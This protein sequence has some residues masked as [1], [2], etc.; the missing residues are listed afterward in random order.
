[1]PSS[2]TSEIPITSNKDSV[3]ALNTHSSLKLTNS[4]FPA[5]SVQFNALLVGYDLIGYVD[6]TNTSPATTDATYT[7][8]KR[9]DQLILHAII[10]SVDASIITMLGNVKNSKQAWDTLTKM[11]ASKTRS[12]IM[13]LKERLSRSTKG[14]KSIA[15]YLHGIKAL[16]DELAIISSP[17]DDVDLV[18]HTLNGLG[19]EYR[20]VTAALRTRENPIG[21]DDLHDLLS[22]F[23]NYLKR[24]ETVQETPLLATANTAY[25]GKQ[26]YNRTGKQAYNQ[27][28]SPSRRIVCQYCEKPG[29]SAKVCYKLRGYPPRRNQTPTAHHTR[30][31]P[32]G[33]SDW[34]LDSGAT[35][36]I[37]ND[38]D[39]LHLAQ[40][41]TGSDQLVV[42]DGSGHTIS[43]IGFEDKA[44]SSK[45]AA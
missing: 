37:T 17:V 2:T 13:H 45:R 41:Y 31:M 32:P 7:R 1:M 38:L 23:E 29:H 33:V 30:A 24:D 22:D 34:I 8:W 5:W 9:Q 28:G 6:G 36:H 21:F 43:N 4:N 26:S 16:S 19:T 11:F 20:E 18:I 27:S 3:I 35:H 39:Q 14:S 25:K 10:S 12:R 40:P 15:E 44:T 42:G